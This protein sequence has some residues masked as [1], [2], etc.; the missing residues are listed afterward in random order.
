[1]LKNF[2]LKLF[3]ELATVVTQKTH[4]V[5]KPTCLFFFSKAKHKTNLHLAG[6][7]YFPELKY[8]LR[9]GDFMKIIPRMGKLEAEGGSNLHHLR[10]LLQLWT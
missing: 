5:K 10:D 4:L 9:E 2:Y 1:M 8:P 7:F 3:P 6:K